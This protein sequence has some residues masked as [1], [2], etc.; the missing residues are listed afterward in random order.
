MFT[1]QVEKMYF[2]AIPF[3]PVHTASVM[4]VGSREDCGNQDGVSRAPAEHSVSV[5]LANIPVLSKTFR[6]LFPSQPWP[7]CSSMLVHGLKALVGSGF[8]SSPIFKSRSSGTKAFCSTTGCNVRQGMWVG[9]GT[10]RSVL[11][12][13]PLQHTEHRS[14]QR[15]VSEQKKKV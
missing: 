12:L 4:P 8:V 9:A 1:S 3:C 14:A 11:G 6:L 13:Q 2:P 7:L 5:P 15:A 10:P